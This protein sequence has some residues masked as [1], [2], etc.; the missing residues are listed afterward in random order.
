MDDIKVT[1]IKHGLGEFVP[2]PD[3]PASFAA[4]KETLK[5][6]GYTL[7][8]ADITGSGALVRDGDR[9]AIEVNPS[10]QRFALAGPAVD[11][12][13]QGVDAASSIEVTGGSQ[14]ISKD[15]A[16]REWQPQGFGERL[17]QPH[18]LGQV[19]LLSHARNVGRQ[20]GGHPLRHG[21]TYRQERRAGRHLNR[22][23]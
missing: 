22:T 4:L 19:P 14:T 6:A 1:D 20:A 11:R 10:K 18:T 15:A 2:K 13:L 9:W 21:V 7:A 23:A 17:R 12:L 5:K 16:I 8:S 3:K